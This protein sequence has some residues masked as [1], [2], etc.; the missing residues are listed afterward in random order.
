LF[1]TDP[2]G[3]P[4]EWR[5]VAIGGGRDAIQEVLEERYDES[6]GV[7]DVVTLALRALKSEIEEIDAAGLSLSTITEDGYD[8]LSTEEIDDVLADIEE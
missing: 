5:A 3:T 8:S 6:A 4:Q 7:N 2:S 1:A